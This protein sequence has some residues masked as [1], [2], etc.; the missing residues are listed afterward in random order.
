MVVTTMVLVFATIALKLAVPYYQTQRLIKEVESLGGMADVSYTGPEWLL[1]WSAEY[2]W[3]FGLGLFERVTHIIVTNLPVDDGWLSKLHGIENIVVLEL[4]GT[5]VTDAGLKSLR[6]R[7]NLAVLS[8]QKTRVT[9]EGLAHLREMT[10]LCN[11]HLDGTRITDAGLEHLRG[12]NNLAWLTVSGTQV[13]GQGLAWTSERAVCMYEINLSDCPVTDE[14][15]QSLGIPRTLILDRTKITDRSLSHLDNSSIE[16]L[17]LIGTQVGD[18]GLRIL[19]EA[20]VESL[21]RL[22][23]AQTRISDAG[24]VSLRRIGPLTHLNLSHTAISDRGAV[25]FQNLRWKGISRAGMGGISHTLDL[26]GTNITDVGLMELVPLEQLD[27]LNLQSTQVTQEGIVIFKN[28]SPSFTVID[29]DP[30][31]MARSMR[32]F[33]GDRRFPDGMM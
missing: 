16:E 18:A 30:E 15:L 17:S 20:N 8:L 5:D 14:G 12:L 22:N 6:T 24:L 29:I 23:L 27:H 26:T 3:H 21:L 2:D 4:S 13:Q 7:K 33:F 31:G 32:K 25:H 1:Y 11:L 28:A 10:G 19:A 9:D